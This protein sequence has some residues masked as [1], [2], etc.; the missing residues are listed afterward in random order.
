M[1]DS[2]AGKEENESKR[3][4]GDV[5]IVLM[6]ILQQIKVEQ[7]LEEWERRKMWVDY[8]VEDH[9][10][11]KLKVTERCR[12]RKVLKMQNICEMWFK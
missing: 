9:E 6:K 2:F 5:D 1:R 3:E 7:D 10:N 4:I 11:V 12:H 8:V